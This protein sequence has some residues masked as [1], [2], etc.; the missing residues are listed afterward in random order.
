MWV[1]VARYIYIYVYLILNI[2]DIYIYV[3]YIYDIYIYVEQVS[4]GSIGWLVK[5]VACFIWF[6]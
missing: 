2:Y 5:I 1:Y 6:A 4:C 3:Y